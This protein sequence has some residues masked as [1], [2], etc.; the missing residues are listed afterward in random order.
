MNI[1]YKNITIRQAQSSD[2]KQLALW[3]NDG[4]VMEHAGFPCGLNITESEIIES[5]NDGLMIIE[6]NNC[7][8][9]ECN[10]RNKGKG[11][12]EIGIKIC[13]SDC[14]NR[15]IGKKVLSMMI[16]WL[17]GNGYSKIVLDTN[18]NNKRA[19]H[20]YESI[21]FIKAKINFNS[22][23]DQMGKLQSSVDYVLTQETFNSYI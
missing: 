16:D 23:T 12:A 13:R 5:I 3:W 20:V 18:L 2:T 6:E 1:R 21:G 8:I 14:Q 10:Y 11:V 9:G 7:P 19:Q 4:E 15:G 22:W 17:F